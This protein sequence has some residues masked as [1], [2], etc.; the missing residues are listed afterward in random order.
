MSPRSAAATAL[1]RRIEIEGVRLALD[2]VDEVLAEGCRRADARN[3]F[4]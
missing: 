2:E 3:G 1:C 4:A